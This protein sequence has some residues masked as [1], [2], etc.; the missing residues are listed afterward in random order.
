MEK[1]MNSGNPALQMSQFTSQINQFSEVANPSVM[2]L[3]GTIIKSAILTALMI[4]AG[5]ASWA[6]C[7]SPEAS[8]G[9]KIGMIIGGL[10]GSLIV[11]IVLFFSQKLAPYLAPAY[12]VC[13]GLL[14]GAISGMYANAF[15][16]IVVQAVLLTVG[17]LCVMLLAYST[18]V[19]KATPMLMKGIIAATG[20]ICLTYLVTFVLSLCGVQGVNMIHQ[21]GTVGII[22][23]LVVV[24]V[25]A[26]NFILD[27]HAI[28]M[29]SRSGAPKY[30][31]WYCA[32]GLLVTLAW[33]YLEVLRLLAK[34]R[35]SD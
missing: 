4:A 20:A 12:A 11:G 28:E 31:E 23:S 18:G 16:G 13:E 29:G 7:H 17:L 1:Q 22:F 34:I 14:L 5:G 6:V 30:M 32:Y 3:N 19:I 8:S 9:L 21:G 15:N 25:A 24:G 26:F 27:F 2:T 35:S 33:L 10:V